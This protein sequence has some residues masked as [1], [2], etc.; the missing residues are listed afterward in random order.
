MRGL[1]PT[2]PGSP[3]SHELLAQSGGSQTSARSQPSIVEVLPVS[4]WVEVRKTEKQRFARIAAIRSSGENCIAWT[5]G[6][7][8]LDW[9]FDFGKTCAR[10]HR[11][12][13]YDPPAKSPNLGALKAL[14]ALKLQKAE[15]G[16]SVAFCE[17][18][19][20]G[21]AF[22]TQTRG[23]VSACMWP[24]L[25]GSDPGRALWRQ[26]QRHVPPS[27]SHF[28]HD[29]CEQSGQRFVQPTTFATRS[30]QSLSDI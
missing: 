22:R 14:K 9:H 8:R 17:A 2:T 18:G 7:L 3:R 15:P 13:R 29:L 28:H 25:F 27:H 1:E 16:G 5:W 4:V 24:W 6:V 23:L 26:R 19:P 30:R 21:I 20:R 10:T 11:A 12:C